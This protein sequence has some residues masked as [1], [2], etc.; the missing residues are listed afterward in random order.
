MSWRSQLS[1]PCG[2]LGTGLSSV[3]PLLGGEG[4]STPAP[5]SEGACRGLGAAVST[6][7]RQAE[8]NL[9]SERARKPLPW[10]VVP[11]PRGRGGKCR[12]CPQ[13][14]F[15]LRPAAGPKPPPQLQKL[16]LLLQQ[17]Q[18]PSGRPQELLPAPPAQQALRPQRGV[19]APPARHAA[20]S[21][22]GVSS[23]ARPRPLLTSQQPLGV[24]VLLL[25]PVRTRLLQPWPGCS[26]PR[27]MV[28][29]PDFFSCL[30]TRVALPPGPVCCRH[31][32]DHRGMG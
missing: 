11:Q 20:S 21:G 13:F 18:S 29:L 22:C 9:A 14:S 17:V 28:L 8:N 1:W 24:S 26:R 32:A 30:A 31:S 19:C 6:A 3:C 27:P 16:L 12:G 5:G 25:P 23:E 2:T 7:R 10:T 4:F 15:I